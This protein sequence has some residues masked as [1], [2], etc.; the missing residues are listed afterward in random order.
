MKILYKFYFYRTCKKQI[1]I[2][3]IKRIKWEFV[4]EYTIRAGS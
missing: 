3:Y 1:L 4:F 2:V